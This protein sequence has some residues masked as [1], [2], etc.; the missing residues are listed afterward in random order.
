M[1]KIDRL[2]LKWLKQNCKLQSSGTL[3]PGL[4]RLQNLQRERLLKNYAPLW[5]AAKRARRRLT[6][7]RRQAGG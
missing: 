1:F 6:R 5:N 4:A 7:V 2:R 3:P